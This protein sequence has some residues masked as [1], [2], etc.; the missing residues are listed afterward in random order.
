[1]C[2]IC[3]ALYHGK[4]SNLHKSC[5]TCCSLSSKNEMSGLFEWA[6]SALRYAPVDTVAGQECCCSSSMKGVWCT[7]VQSNNDLDFH[8]QCNVHTAQNLQLWL[9]QEA[10]FNEDWIIDAAHITLAEIQVINAPSTFMASADVIFYSLLLQLS[11]LPTQFQNE[12]I[13]QDTVHRTYVWEHPIYGKRLKYE[14]SVCNPSRFL[15]G[16]KAPNIC[17]A[18]TW[19][20][21]RK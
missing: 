8:W 2:T 20:A 16:L 3:G 14:K 17:H 9:G 13:P 15:A 21:G 4:S 18:A 12:T 1:M 5:S 11:I 6:G 7:T 10:M 19:T